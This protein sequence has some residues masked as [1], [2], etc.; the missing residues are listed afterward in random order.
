MEWDRVP[1]LVN[2]LDADGAR[3]ARL[4]ALEAAAADGCELERGLGGQQLEQEGRSNH[5][6]SR[7]GDPIT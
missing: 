2:E 1:E 3:L 4:D 6:C 5:L 7:A